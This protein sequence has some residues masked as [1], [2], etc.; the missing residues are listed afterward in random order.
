MRKNKGR[1][2]KANPLNKA[3]GLC[4]T[5]SHYFVIQQK[6]AQAGVDVA[7]FL[8]QVAIHGQVKTRWKAEEKGVF[9][10][11]VKITNAIH[12]FVKTAEKE[13]APETMLHFIKYRDHMD[14]AIKRLTGG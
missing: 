2:K 12:Q 11:L 8:R 14:A 6:A 3:I 9:L 5:H 1:P 7:E 4:M 13:G 10:S